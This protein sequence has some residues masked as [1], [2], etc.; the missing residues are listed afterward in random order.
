M[1]SEEASFESFV[2]FSISLTQAVHDAKHE[3][4]GSASILHLWDTDSLYLPA[5]GYA[6]LDDDGEVDRYVLVQ[7]L[8]SAGFLGRVALLNPHRAEL[9]GLIATWRTEG[10]S[11]AKPDFSVRDLRRQYS[12]KQ[13]ISLS[14]RIEDMDD[15][16]SERVEDILSE[17]R[18]IGKEEFVYLESSYGD[19]RVRTNN[20]LDRDLLDLTPY[21]APVSYIRNT[22]IFDRVMG[23]LRKIRPFRRTSANAVD[24]AALA[25]LVEMCRAVDRG[26]S[27]VYPRFFTS[28]SAVR[29]LYEEDPWIRKQLRLRSPEEVPHAAG[30]AWRDGYYYF[31]R[32]MFPALRPID[33]AT[34]LPRRSPSSHSLEDLAEISVEL[35]QAVRNERALKELARRPMWGDSETSLNQ[36]VF[37]LERS[38]MTRIW[39]QYAEHLSTYPEIQLKGLSLLSQSPYTPGFV[40]AHESIIEDRFH[41]E[42]REIKLHRD[43]VQSTS[44]ALDDFGRVLGRHR[45]S[46]VSD[47]GSARWGVEASEGSD[48]IGGDDGLRSSLMADL[49]TTFNHEITGGDPAATERAIAMLFAVEEFVLARDYLEISRSDS[50]VLK[51][52]RSIIPILSG[53]GYAEEFSTD[54]LAAIRSEWEELGGEARVRCLLGYAW[55]IFRG[56]QRHLAVNAS[57]N[58]TSL[59]EWAI[60]TVADHAEQFS[61]AALVQAY[62]FLIYASAITDVRFDEYLRYLRV[63]EDEALSAGDYHLSDTVGY[64]YYRLAL[65]ESRLQSDSTNLYETYLRRSRTHLERAHELFPADAEVAEHLAIVR[66]LHSP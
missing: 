44:V 56:W 35:E 1:A 5:R 22:E 60:I 30:T 54:R 34:G 37:D 59:V 16:S 7:S 27:R 65:R 47:L 4:D 55:A 13:A 66:A 23:A 36:I 26:E 57:K 31:V 51:M 46:L 20:L 14:R 63:L 21:G 29:R 24:S 32:A 50:V 6:A 53:S 28:S 3:A 25:T 19:W 33:A 15:M 39:L 61:S 12:A 48:R 2:R 64:A 45:F 40:S 38:R 41:A 62:N 11:A 42:I 58:D 17:L 43:A 52:M 9:L 10:R 18:K 49:Y 8:Y